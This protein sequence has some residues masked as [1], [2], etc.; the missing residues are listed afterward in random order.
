MLRNQAVVYYIVDHLNN[1]Y[2]ILL[3]RPPSREKMLLI[4]CN[5]FGCIFYYWHENNN[6]GHFVI[7][8]KPWYIIL[9]I[10]YTLHRSDCKMGTINVS[11]TQ[12]TICFTF[13]LP[14]AARLSGCLL[15]LLCSI[16]L[17]FSNTARPLCC[18]EPKEKEDKIV[19]LCALFL[20]HSWLYF[21]LWC[22]WAVH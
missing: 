8:G 12:P 10:N 18:L 20:S 19:T 15:S 9:T 2:I 22:M 17:W 13:H 3:L 6:I 16:K 14:N 1:I 11:G 4:R 5:N 21:L 7:R